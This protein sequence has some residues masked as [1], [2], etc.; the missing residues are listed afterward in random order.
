V[1]DCVT[2]D[3]PTG[4]ISVNRTDPAGTLVLFKTVTVNVVVWPTCIRAGLT[5][6]AT[7]KSSGF[8]TTGTAITKTVQLA[9]FPPEVTTIVFSPVVLKSGLYVAPEPFEGLASGPDQ[10]YVPFPPT[11]AKLAV[12]FIYIV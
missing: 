7:T 12:W 6:F 11:A 3:S 4:K 5:C 2:K 9:C 8:T 1:T 10:T